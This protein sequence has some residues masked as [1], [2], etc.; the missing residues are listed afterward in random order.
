MKQLMM[1]G[2]MV[3]ILGSLLVLPAG[4]ADAADYAKVYVIPLTVQETGV[5]PGT[6]ILMYGHGPDL[7]LQS[8]TF[9]GELADSQ[10]KAVRTFPIW[11]PRIRF[12]DSAYVK[13]DGTVSK[14]SGVLE[15][16]ERAEVTLVVPFSKDYAYFNLYDDRGTKV[17]SVDLSPVMKK[18]CAA[19]P[20]DLDCGS[21]RPVPLSPLS[22]I[23][24]M[25]LLFIAAGAGFLRKKRA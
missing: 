11:D 10:G 6:V 23:G 16:A 21:T 13:P 12:G 9:R 3:L 25:A 20:G 7:G 4:A 1:T 8:G 24:G 2:I 19:T 14:V 15:N 5:S 22:L 18:F 17:T